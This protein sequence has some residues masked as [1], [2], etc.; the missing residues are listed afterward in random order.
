MTLLQHHSLCQQIGQEVIAPLLIGFT[1]CLIDQV[2]ERQPR[3]IYFLERDAT[4]LQK[5]YTLAR[6]AQP[7]LPPA[8]SLPA[9]R[10]ALA[11][12]AL[13]NLKEPT[14]TRFMV[15]GTQ[16]DSLQGHLSR[17]SID[18]AAHAKRLQAAEI[19]N[20]HEPLPTADAQHQLAQVCRIL[21]PLILI[22]A[23]RER[24]GL[25][26]ML[27][28]YSI[29]QQELLL[30]VD[31]GWRGTAQRSL[32]R[33]LDQEYR[34]PHLH[35]CYLGTFAEMQSRLRPD[36]T[37]AGYLCH[38][39][40]PSERYEAL[41]QGVELI[42]TLLG[43]RT[44]SLQ[45]INRTPRGYYLNRHPSA[46]TP[47]QGDCIDRI[48][49]AAL[50]HFQRKWAS[51]PVLNVQE[52]FAPLQRLITYP[53]TAEAQLFGAIHHDDGPGYAK[54][55]RPLAQ[56]ASG[57]SYFFQPASLR[58]DYSKAFWKPGFRKQVP[59]LL[60]RRLSHPA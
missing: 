38:L 15:D 48:Q 30:C 16:P 26:R 43:A 47:S 17:F 52:A 24:A 50:R 53:S 9:S 21:Q 23:A 60:R 39:S 12:A 27:Q 44:G 49:Q 36:S 59:T 57:L 35:G 41:M 34:V 33:I 45:Q 22:K 19:H 55:A 54:A 32:R 20:W 10:R 8:I 51:S 37:A 46:L 6:Y 56:P 31:I 11:F 29:P 2:Q 42:E 40:K 4:L 14:A 18:L 25:K 7:E 28:D 3:R 13:Y 5:A 58:Q 1:Q